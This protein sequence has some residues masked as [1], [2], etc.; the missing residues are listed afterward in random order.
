M[1]PLFH[2]F[3]VYFLISNTSNVI[4]IS[5]SYEFSESTSWTT[6]FEQSNCCVEF[7][8]NAI[9]RIE[10]ARYFSSYSR[11][12]YIVQKLDTY[13]LTLLEKSMNG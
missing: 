7:S 11:K 8:S 5:G 2:C 4:L 1:R 3:S 6:I 12:Y 9:S 10:V 13:V